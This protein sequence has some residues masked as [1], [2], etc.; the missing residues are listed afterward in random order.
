MKRSTEVTS[1]RLFDRGG[2]SRI[3]ELFYLSPFLVDCGHMFGLQL[4]INGELLLCLVLLTGANIILA[5]TVVC[6][7]RTGVQFQRALVLGQ[8]L[9]QFV[10]V[11][12]EDPKLQVCI[13]ERSIE[14]YRLL[15][16]GLDLLKID[17]GLFQPFCLPQTDRVIV[18][19]Q[20]VVRL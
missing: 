8:R 5:E 13:G 14:G 9:G 3:D 1:S 18:L 19:G 6:I 12:V 7:R 2:L 4:L 16:Q 11:G 15:Q 10:L 17:A 20:R